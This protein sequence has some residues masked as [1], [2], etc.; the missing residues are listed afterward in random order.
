MFSDI[1]LSKNQNGE[2]NE[3]NAKKHKIVL[4]NERKM[5]EN[6]KKLPQK[7]AKKKNRKIEY[8]PIVIKI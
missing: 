7:I 1:N 5:G 3:E 2:K 8:K 6:K 4:K